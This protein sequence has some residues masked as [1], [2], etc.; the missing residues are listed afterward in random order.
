MESTTLLDPD[1]LLRMPGGKDYELI[2][3][4]PVERARGAK[5][6]AI[7][8]RLTGIMH[9][10]VDA[11]RLGML[12]GPRTGYRCFPTR[13]RTI[14]KS[15]LSFV[16]RGR[17]P[18]DEAPEGD[19]LIPPDLAVESVSPN[20]TFEEVEVKVK[21][22]LGAGVRLIWIISP[23]ART[24]MV[25]RPGKNCTALDETDTLTGEDVLPG[26]TCPVADLFS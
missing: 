6:S 16:A 2:D 8:V 5:L 18:N 17:L 26:F 19:I 20:D 7:A 24:V 14:R 12:F 15:S 13:P 9:S 25:R 4:R 23:T 22:L 10:Y 3:G 1:D 21:D 11:H